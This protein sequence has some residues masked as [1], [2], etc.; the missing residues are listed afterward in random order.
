[1]F[2]RSPFADVIARQLELF[3]EDEAELIAE[4]REKELEYDRADRDGAEEAYGDYMDAVE[5]AT[6]SLADMRDRFRATLDEPAAET[7]ENEFNRAVRKRW[8]AFGLEIE[9]R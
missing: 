4:C 1:M 2:R 7:Y 6:E 3:A 5:S 8:P 9:N